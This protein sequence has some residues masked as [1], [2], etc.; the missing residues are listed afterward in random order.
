MKK[1]DEILQEL[2]ISKVKLAKYLGVSRQ[3]IY[4]YLELESLNKWPKEKKM[5][6]F[7][8]LDIKDGSDSSL[9]K[10][11]VNSDY[12]I[13]VEKRLNESLNEKN[14]TSINSEMYDIK[15]LKKDEQELFSKIMYLIKE[16]FTDEYNHSKNIATLNYLFHALQSIDNVE[17]IK[18]FLAYISKINGLTDPDDFKYNENNQYLF[19]SI[20]YSA[21]TLYSSGQA[22]SRS[23]IAEYREKFVKTAKRSKE[24][25]L[26]RT[27][28][29]TGIYRQALRELGYSDSDFNIENQ[30]EIL[31]KFAE[32]ESRKGN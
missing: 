27:E 23:K 24:E 19:E 8:L 22:S 28:Q 26:S 12:I 30:D 7:K 29:L 14:S 20:I 15:K 17:E 32:I 10:I 5:L 31:A 11:K 2:G 25:Q 16:K 9:N 3:M 1:L 13:S 21:L 6:L 18:Y 4:N